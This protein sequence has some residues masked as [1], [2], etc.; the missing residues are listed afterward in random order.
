MKL[1]ILIEICCQHYI[2]I[3]TSIKRIAETMDINYVDDEVTRNKLYK[4]G[5]TIYEVDT[6]TIKQ[7]E[8]Q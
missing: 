5:Y 1:Y 6:E 8:E 2:G 4:D 7:W 3:Y